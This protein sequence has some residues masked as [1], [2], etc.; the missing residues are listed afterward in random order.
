MCT[1][2]KLSEDQQ[3]I[4]DEGIIIPMKPHVPLNNMYNRNPNHFFQPQQQAFQR[5]LPVYSTTVT[6]T[7][8]SMMN[9]FNAPNPHAMNHESE[10]SYIQPNPSQHQPLQQK[11]SMPIDLVNFLIG[12]GM[13]EKCVTFQ[14]SQ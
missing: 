13:F 14:G 6:N 3:A 12:W 8:I 10:H 4:E 9:Y 2:N 7:P 5:A 11:Q 1:K